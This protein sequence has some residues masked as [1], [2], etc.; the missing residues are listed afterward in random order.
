MNPGFSHWAKNFVFDVMQ[1]DW[2]TVDF[3]DIPAPNR[4]KDVADFADVRDRPMIDD[5]FN[6]IE[7]VSVDIKCEA[8]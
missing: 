6:S 8:F 7:V 3:P 4:E 2:L 1:C 5:K